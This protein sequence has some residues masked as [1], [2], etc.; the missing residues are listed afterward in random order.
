MP[1]PSLRPLRVSTGLEVGGISVSKLS[2]LRASF[3]AAGVRPAIGVR[4]QLPWAGLGV[5]FTKSAKLKFVPGVVGPKLR[6][7][8]PVVPGVI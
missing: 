2:F 6:K 1:S 4:V 7:P 3:A 5:T 8:I